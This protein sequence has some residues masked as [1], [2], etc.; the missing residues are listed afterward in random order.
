MNSSTLDFITKLMKDTMKLDVHYFL[1]PYYELSTFDRYF[2]SSFEDASIL[3]KE[4]ENLIRDFGHATY[5]IY[6]D[7]YQL[8]YIFFY[9]YKDSKDLISIGPYFTDEINDDY[10]INLLDRHKLN[11]LDLQHLKGFLYSI[12]VI[13]NNL[14]LVSILNTL[15]NYINPSAEPFSIHY[16]EVLKTEQD[17]QTF[18][19]KNDFEA[20]TTQVSTRYQLEK[21]LH[22][23]IC[24]GD[25]KLAMEVAKKFLDSPFEPRIKNSLRDHKA[26]MIS[27]NTLFRKA[28]EPNEI[29]PIY[30][31]EI[32]AKY[33][34]MIENTTNIQTLDTLYEKMI[35]DYCNL[36]KNKS[37][38]QYSPVIRQALHYIDFNLCNPISNEEMAKNFN[39]S[40][41]Y[42]S[43]QFKKEVG[44]TIVK[45]T[46]TLKIKTAL[47][48]LNTSNL[49]IQ[50]IASHVGIY[51]YNYFTKVFKKEIGMPPSEYRK[52]L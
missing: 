39:I 13:A 18:I 5:H 52:K 48:L 33:V 9:P 28:I 24:N 38:K 3:Y 51:D 37:T 44:T 43:S 26:L 15:I 8:N 50:D 25:R 34:N 30:L 41:P 14:Q 17:K 40:I 7:S 49:P 46:N 11:V 16:D 4:I 21:E 42:L 12:P 23:A 27:A 35:R 19:A 10:W 36:V 47:K 22:S 2:R 6:T 45:Y 32:S 31:H 20:Y 29:H 1:E